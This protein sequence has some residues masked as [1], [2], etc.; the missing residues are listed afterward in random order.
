AAEPTGDHYGADAS[1]DQP[2]HQA[3][4]RPQELTGLDH[5]DDLTLST[6]GSAPSAARSST[7]PAG[8]TLDLFGHPI[9][10]SATGVS[11]SAVHAGSPPATSLDVNTTGRPRPGRRRLSRSLRPPR[12]PG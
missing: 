8:G 9:V 12:S 5:C 11:S 10:G 4:D 3:F 7:E 1:V 6:R 2:Q